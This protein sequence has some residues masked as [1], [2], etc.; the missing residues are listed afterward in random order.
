MPLIRYTA[1]DFDALKSAMLAQLP[2]LAPAWT[3]LNEGELGMALLNLLAGSG[4]MLGYYIDRLQDE[5]YL[6][7]ATLRESVMKLTR[8]IDYKLSR[9][10]AAK[11]VLRFSLPSAAGAS[12][13]IPAYTQ[14]RTADGAVF[15]TKAAATLFAGTT[16]VDVEAY[17]GEF[18]SDTFTGNGAD[19]QTFLLAKNNVAQNFLD[20]FV[21]NVLWTEDNS[22]VSPKETSVYEVQTDVN[23]NAVLR[24]SRFMGDVPSQNAT[25]QVNYI[26]TRGAAGNI[27]A[28]L[29]T[30]LVS[31]ISGGQNLAVTNTTV[32][33]GGKDRETLDEAR[34][35]APRQLRTLNRAVTLQDYV[36]LLETFPKVAKAQAINHN[37]YVECYVAPDDG[38]S[39]FIPSY[40]GFTLNGNVNGGTLAPGLL[41][42]VQVTVKDANG[43][44]T[45]TWEYN[46]ADRAVLT[47]YK[48]F[49]TGGSGTAS[50]TVNR[51][52]LPAGATAW[53]V[54]VGTSPTTMR[55]ATESSLVLSA[56]NITALP[57]GT[58]PLAPTVNTTGVRAESGAVS[59]RQAAESF[60]EDRRAIGTNFALFNPTY[61]PVNVTATIT[62]YSNFSQVAV[63]GAV[64][65]ALADLFSFDSQ[66][67]EEDVTLAS[68][69]MAIMG[70]EGVRTVAFTAPSGD[71]AIAN[72]QLATLGT[73]ALTM[74]G[75]VV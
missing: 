24:F 39:L 26:S 68:L 4:D 53:R 73:V 65:E 13:V 59:L 60:L 23:E 69:Y 9:P 67:F 44:E 46:P 21:S 43:G 2:V 63:K 16:F 28:G 62:V 40:N 72:G 6:P 31:T 45:T 64:Q 30:T 36:D 71:V 19:V 55:L 47:K 25:V 51:G 18:V 50:I 32:A 35:N 52:T 8:L 42:Y 58:Q 61:V 74:Q 14:A 33:S 20:V 66:R 48:S 41:V 11:T 70:V 38:A 37:G 15:T 54:Y 34:V 5:M 7:T 57:A 29:V 17:Q 22:T 56:Y 1:K 49:T 3:N 27:G 12:L 75:G 10:V